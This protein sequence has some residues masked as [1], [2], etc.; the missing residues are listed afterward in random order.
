MPNP[1]TTIDI[2]ATAG[3]VSHLNSACGINGRPIKQAHTTKKERQASPESRR[4]GAHK[5]DEEK[6]KR[7]SGRK[8]AKISGYMDDPWFHC[9]RPRISFIEDY[10]LQHGCCPA[11]SDFLQSTHLSH[12]LPNL[13]FRVSATTLGSKLLGDRSFRVHLPVETVCNQI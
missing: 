11:Q 7:M 10:P 1:N 4:R 3:R 2:S 9:L 13:L 5:V 12:L 6:S 8:L